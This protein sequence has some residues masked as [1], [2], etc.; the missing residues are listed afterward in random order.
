MRE[1]NDDEL[2]ARRDLIDYLSRAH[3]SVAAMRA[4]WTA[5]GGRASNMPDSGSS[6]AARW[7]EVVTRVG[8][9]LH[10]DAFAA[11][12]RAAHPGSPDDALRG[13]GWGDV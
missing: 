8:N 11:A 1:L 13:L 9:Q 10:P 12:V 5:A 3:P 7:S 2:K 6:P 4:I